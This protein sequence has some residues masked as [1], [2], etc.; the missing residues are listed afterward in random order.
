MAIRVTVGAEDQP[1]LE[2]MEFLGEQLARFNAE[3][4]GE[5]NFRRL[6]LFLR[7]EDGSIVGGLVG[8]TYWQWLYVDLLWVD[9][10]LRGQGY[11]GQLLAAAEQEARERGCLGAFL[12]TFSFQAPSFY[13]RRGYVVCG[14]VADF[15]TGHRRYGLKKNL[16]SD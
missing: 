11:G 16:Q 9:E 8:A 4:A 2:D 13:L 14:E 5:D 3:Q 15:P 7:A 12:D 10:R 6:A 1:R